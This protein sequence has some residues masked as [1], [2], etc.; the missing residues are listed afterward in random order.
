[1]FIK[2]FFLSQDNRHLNNNYKEKQTNWK[3]T[4]TQEQGQGIRDHKET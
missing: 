2:V 3:K 1:M 4:D